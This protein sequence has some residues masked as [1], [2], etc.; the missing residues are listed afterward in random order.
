MIRKLICT[1]FWH[2]YSNSV[3]KIHYVGRSGVADLHHELSVASVGL[4]L[5]VYPFVLIYQFIY[6]KV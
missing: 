5:E 2:F 6:L 1:N 3:D 4:D